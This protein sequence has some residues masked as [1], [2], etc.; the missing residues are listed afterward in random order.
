ML[1]FMAENKRIHNLH[2]QKF[3]ELVGFQANTS[4]FQKKILM[5]L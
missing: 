4:S 1:N 3:S 2:E 5:P